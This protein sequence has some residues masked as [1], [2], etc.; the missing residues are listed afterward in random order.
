MS[1]ERSGLEFTDIVL[2]F[3]MMRSLVCPRS[4]L[5][6]KSRYFV[7]SYARRWIIHGDTESKSLYCCP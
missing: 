7:S 4:S 5:S 1:R 6:T 3:G 2:A